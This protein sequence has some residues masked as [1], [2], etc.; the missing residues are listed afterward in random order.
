M[1]DERALTEKLPEGS[2]GET[3][4]K[5]R[6]SAECPLATG[7]Q[8][9][10]YRVLR[11]LGAG[12]MGEVYVA[13][14]ARLGRQVAVKVIR[15]STP[16]T[17]K[18]RARFEQ[19]AR[20]ASALSHPNIITIFDIGDA[21]EQPF[22]VMELLDGRSLRELLRQGLPAADLFRLATQIA[23]A[24]STSHERGIVHRD[25]KPEN[26]FVTS[27][28][29]AK[30][31]DFGVARIRQ[32]AV[33]EDCVTDERLTLQGSAIGTIG[34]MAPEVIAGQP[35]DFRSDIFSFGA[36][37]YEMAAGRRAFAGSSPMDI[38]AASLREDPP[39]LS[40]VRP[41]LPNDLS[42]IVERSMR[43]DPAARWAST[44][45]V[46]DQ[47]AA[48]AASTQSGSR[49]AQKTRA[50]PRFEFPVLGREAELAAIRSMIIDE[51]ARLVSLTGAGGSG[52]TRLAL[53]A[54][55]RLFEWFGG[56]VFF[57]PLASVT[58]PE[59]VGAAIA[60]AVGA[61][62][63]ARAPL[64]AVIANLRSTENRSLLVIDNFEQVIDAAPIL[65]ELL[66]D[67][68]ELTILVTS[69]EILHLYAER[70]IPVQPL[71]VPKQ[72]E[73]S[74]TADVMASPAVTLFIQRAKAVNPSVPLDD[75]NVSAI[76]EICRRLDGLPLAIELAAARTRLMTPR[77]M[78]ARI[79]ES[80][81]LLTG[82]AR[83]LPGRHQ[84]LRRT[85]D[86]SYELLPPAEQA[87]IRRLSVFAGSFTLEQAEA[88][89]DPFGRLNIGIE[90][91]IGS[92][93]DK[94]LLVRKGE[95]DG[96]PRFAMLGMVRDY[97][98][99][100]LAA[101]DE[102]HDAR[103]A[104]AAYYLVL[105]EEGAQTARSGQNAVWLSRLGREH[106]NLRA[107]LEWTTTSGMTE[108]GL[109]IA[110]GIFPFWERS[111]HL[112]EGRKRLDAL[113]AQP[114]RGLELLR[115]RAS[116]ATSVLACIQNDFDV[117]TARAEESLAIYRAL[118][119]RGGIAVTCNCLGVIGTETRQLDK[120]VDSLEE[121]LSVWK[122]IGDEASYA[123]SLTNLARVRRLQGDHAAASAM[124]VETESLFRRID[125]KASASWALNH[126]GD[127]ARELGQLEEASNHYS[128]ALRA[129]RELGDSWG[130]ATSL[131][132]I[133]N[134]ARRKGLADEAAAAYR[135]SLEHFGRLGHTRGIAR[136]LEAMAVLAADREQYEDSLTLAGS[137]SRIRD[138]IGAP[139]PA[140][141]LAE[142]DRELDRARNAL[143]VEGA[144]QPYQCGR[145][146]GVGEAIA[147]A[148]GATRA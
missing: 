48:L 116:F 134:L 129:F 22:I 102:E 97:A 24:L 78:L 132:D 18:A 67:C 105:A 108:W 140:E 31:L 121:S 63:P 28:G 4:A 85:L 37:L 23:D 19:E 118:D 38:L 12:G 104:H 25:L 58:D 39:P 145:C 88:V 77:A 42:V 93:V 64:P 70:N 147:F 53:T 100:Q 126:R 1:S 65:S 99:E 10:R 87:L 148:L 136:V 120:A 113:L 83:D 66:T 96:E 13:E 32:N 52:K 41:D 62:D 80:L 59:L 34:Y 138:V 115:A 130:I 107:A 74:S 112:S 11:P 95:D 60:Q 146:M 40:T 131:A 111:E 20:A 109:R 92:L 51:R 35:A 119:D 133:G 94:S 7:T 127:V 144:R 3:V 98:A 84:T 103:K 8:L 76:A 79:G 69:R 49:P 55:E 26:V 5:I 106:D 110:V 91:G 54:A 101:S 33:D 21:N 36:M 30:I 14:D 43:K 15:G 137:A 82:G 117:A 135:E 45:A 114:S 50:L 68:S 81:K 141:E 6:V 47:V 17:P 61:T 128:S 46:R 124:Y 71:P 75:A 142:L 125:D 139:L 143:A 27:E 122:T 123:R 29:N 56:R 73:G 57:V 90:D 89:A 72:T 2:D 16:L 9:G 44:R 86:W